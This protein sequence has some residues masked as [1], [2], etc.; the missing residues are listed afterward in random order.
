MLFVE[1]GMYMKAGSQI[2]SKNSYYGKE[3]STSK[4]MIKNTEWFYSND[5]NTTM[6]EKKNSEE[7]SKKMQSKKETKREK[8]EKEISEWKELLDSGEIDQETYESEKNRL[9]KKIDNM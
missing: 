7:Q 1:C 5:A 9:L 4:K 3:K 6:N 8:L 2:N